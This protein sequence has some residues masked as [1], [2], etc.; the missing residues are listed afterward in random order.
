MRCHQCHSEM[1]QTDSVTEG[2]AHQTWYHCPVCAADQTVS[3]PCEV[4]VRRIGKVQRWSSI[5]PD[6]G[7]IYS[8][9]F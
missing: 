8:G 5:A 4:P 7:Q 6:S 1:R 9:A 2:R 3:R